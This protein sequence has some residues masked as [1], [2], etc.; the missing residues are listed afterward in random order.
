MLKGLKRGLGPWRGGGGI[1]AL[2]L[3]FSLVQLPQEF[4]LKHLF[5]TISHLSAKI[6]IFWNCSQAF[7]TPQNYSKPK[8][9]KQCFSLLVIFSVC[10]VS[11][12][13]VRW[14]FLLHPFR[15]T[16]EMPRAFWEILRNQVMQQ[17]HRH[18]PTQPNPAFQGRV[19]GVRWVLPRQPLGQE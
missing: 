8:L 10:P 3:T 6:K 14:F 11:K 19:E 9:R 4:I 5:L 15:N 18:N 16:L 1:F 12:T 13:K 17:N 2:V 7:P